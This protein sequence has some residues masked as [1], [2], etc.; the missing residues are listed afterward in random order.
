[1][2]RVGLLVALALAAPAA[3]A[4]PTLWQRAGDPGSALRAR[5]RVR[6]EQLFE[7]ANDERADREILRDL[8]LGS[9]ALLELSGGP[10][11]DPWQSVLVGRVLVDAQAGR[12]PDAIRFLQRGL[13]ELPN[14]D[15]KRAGLFDLGLA[16][17]LTGEHELAE[18]AFSAALGLAWDPDD[19]A[20]VHRNRGKARM[21]GGDLAGAVA[22]FRAAVRLARNVEVL[23]LSH[24]GLGV[25]LERGGDYPQGL[26][27]V[28]RG[29]AIQLPVPPYPSESVLDLPSLR[30]VPAYDVSYFR[31]LG[32]MAEAS[33]AEAPELERAAYAAA[34]DSWDEYL[35]P[36]AAHA[37]RFV[38]NARRHRQRCA[39]AL[40]RLARAERV[41]RS[42]SGG[43]R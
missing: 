18:R 36:A 41:A 26:R 24:F 12:E 1:M 11:R 39:D 43:V 42:R 7:Q 30:W 10:A 34:L 19:R 14:S 8:S 31:A 20:S 6:A 2:K 33:S 28:A 38:P 17:M 32:A 15:F 25:A 9:A 5:A 21:L 29:A 37:D 3:R 4:E 23:A 40:L 35:P 22:D 13:S 16:G 27:E